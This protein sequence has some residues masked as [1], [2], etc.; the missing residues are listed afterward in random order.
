MFLAKGGGKGGEE[1]MLLFAFG[2]ARLPRG[3]CSRGISSRRAKSSAPESARRG[4]SWAASWLVIKVGLNGHARLPAATF[5]R[6]ISGLSRLSP[7]IKAA[8]RRLGAK[9]A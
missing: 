9:A 4:P 5:L 1:G 8:L 6:E 3:Q 7:R 2:E